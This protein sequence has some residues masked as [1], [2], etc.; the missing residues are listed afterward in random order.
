MRRTRGARWKA[1]LDVHCTTVE[2]NTG[3]KHYDWLYYQRHDI[4]GFTLMVL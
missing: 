1:G 3:L 2:Y 4:E